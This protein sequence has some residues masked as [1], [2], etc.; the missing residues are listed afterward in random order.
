M[1]PPGIERYRRS[2]QGER[3]GASE[4]IEALVYACSKESQTREVTQ[5]VPGGNGADGNR[6]TWTKPEG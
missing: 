3:A 5:T 6:A 1:E 2:P 4:S